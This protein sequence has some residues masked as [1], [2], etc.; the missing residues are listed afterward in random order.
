MSEL[1]AALNRGRSL[2]PATSAERWLELV[3]HPSEDVA[4]HACLGLARLA[5]F[6][7]SWS[8]ADPLL[9]LDQPEALPAAL[10]VA[11]VLGAKE[12]IPRLRARLEL[13]SVTDAVG[14]L[15]TLDGLGDDVRASL[16]PERLEAIEAAAFETTSFVLAREG[17]PAELIASAVVTELQDRHRGLLD[18]VGGT[19]H[20]LALLASMAGEGSLTAA[21]VEA[22]RR[23]DPVAVAD[24]IARLVEPDAAVLP[25]DE[26]EVA[27]RRRMALACRETILETNPRR[28]QLDEVAAAGFVQGLHVRARSRRDAASAVVLALLGDAR[29]WETVAAPDDE[30][31]E[32]VKRL[33]ADASSHRAREAL[34]AC[35]LGW[36]LEA[37]APEVVT[38]ARAGSLLWG[39]V[40]GPLA[41]RL[42]GPL[43]SALGEKIGA[44]GTLSLL[45]QLVSTDAE[46]QVVPLASASDVGVRVYLPLLVRSFP[47]PRVLDAVRRAP[48][49][50]EV[51]QRRRV[52]LLSELDPSLASL[53]AV[54]PS[55]LCQACGAIWNV[56][57]TS[58]SKV[59]RALV[60]EPAVA[61]PGCG[62]TGWATGAD[63]TDTAR[64]WR[65]LPGFE[66]HESPRHLLARLSD[67]VDP[68]PLDLVETLLLCGE[69]DQ[70]VAALQLA[71]PEARLVQAP[72]AASLLLKLGLPRAAKE[73]VVA[74]LRW[75]DAWAMWQQDDVV[76]LKAALREACHQLDEPTPEV[77]VV[78]PAAG[79]LDAVSIPSGKVGRNEPCPCGSGRKYKRCHGG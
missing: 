21:D 77:E 56:S 60:P 65:A 50:D 49:L 67:E 30:A 7:G 74:A 76:A 40:H 14:L 13:A 27:L 34:V 55:L 2:V 57:E 33:A 44:D 41:T 23:R 59:G 73:V 72:R 39:Y 26:R 24:A 12:A 62:A 17:R 4:R 9:D 1:L 45:A 70:A 15:R 78:Q 11:A 71:S 20:E 37:F 5:L 58:L 46:G 69:P 61:C 63:P 36:R 68:N 38:A 31:V 22:W 54:S 42:E 66:P 53:D 18:R 75:E 51:E 19:S 16:P 25:R 3:H 43:L 79:G 10:R 29:V 47:T 28:T 64:G 52:A 48:P 6:E 32:L 35:A 8:H